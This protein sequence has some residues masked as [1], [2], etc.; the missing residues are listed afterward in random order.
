MANDV[1]MV[2]IYLREADHGRRNT[3]MQ[4]IFS[5]L[6]DRHAVQGATVFRG[7]AGFGASGK[8]HA[9][10]LLQLTVD[11]PLMIE[12]Y[13]EPAVAETAIQLIDD[14]VPGGHVVS[15]PATCHGAAS[16]RPTRG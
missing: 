7:I 15:W 4:E 14:L 10:D 13:G 9:N 12:F 2:R 5:I 1:L 6:R 3:L 8:V 16:W 11:L